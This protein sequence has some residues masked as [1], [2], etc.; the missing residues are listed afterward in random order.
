MSYKVNEYVMWAEISHNAKGE[1]QSE[2]L[3]I[4]KIVEP[5]PTIYRVQLLKF[6]LDELSVVIRP[7]N[8]IGFDKEELDKEGM[9]LGFDSELIGLLYL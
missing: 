8:V 6:P 2:G 4:F 5:K 1:I 7:Y 3:Y 9:S